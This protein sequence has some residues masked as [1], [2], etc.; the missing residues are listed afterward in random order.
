MTHYYVVTGAA[1]FIGSHLVRALNQR[2]IGY[3]LAVDN[4]TRA[5]KFANLVGC[6]IADYLDK[7]DFL[8]RLLAGE[9]E[10]ALDAVLHQGACS[11]TMAVDGRYVMENN[12]RYSLAL[13]DFCL[14]EEVPFLYASSAAVYGTGRVFREVPGCEAP[15]NVYGYSKYLFD[16]VVRRRP[17]DA[18]APPPDILYLNGYGT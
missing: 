2:G 8:E 13:L 6:Q 4:L 3:I 16:K 1:G 14:E 15:L 10:G 12:Y 9:F 18:S 17:P 7:Q 5:D 11:D